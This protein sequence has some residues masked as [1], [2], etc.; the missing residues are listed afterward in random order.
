MADIAAALHSG[1]RERGWHVQSRF[2]GEDLQA[3]LA[4]A[5]WVDDEAFTAYGLD[6]STITALRAW[7]VA[8]SDDL[9]GRLIEEE[10]P[11]DQD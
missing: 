4:G 10:Q 3:N 8:W 11:H 5:E 6:A 2:E 7:A 1:L 9:A